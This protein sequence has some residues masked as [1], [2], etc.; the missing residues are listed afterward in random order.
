[1]RNLTALIVL[2]CLGLSAQAQK[3]LSV[4]ILHTND[5]HGH[6]LPYSY[7]ETFDPNEAIAR[8][9]VRRNIGGA[10]R[11]ASLVE[12]I[13][14]EK[15]RVVL[16][17]DSGDMMDGS[18]FSTEYKGEADM[19]VMNAIGLDA[20]VPGNHEF[21]N[22]FEQVQKLISMAKH[23]VVLANATRA[24]SGEPLAKPYIIKTVQG[25]RFGIFGLTTPSGQSYPGAVRDIR[26]EDPEAA[27]AKLVPIL[28]SQCDI[29]IAV[30]HIGNREDQ[31]LARKV[32]GI[33]IIVG[34][35]S[36]S[37]LPKH[38]LIP[39]STTTP[40]S[41]NG[42]LIVQAFQWSGVLGRLDIELTTNPS[43]KW[44][45]SRGEGRLLPITESIPEHKGVKKIVDSYWVPIAPKFGKV[46]CEA[47]DDIAHKGDDFAEYHMVADAIRAEMGTEVHF[48]NPGGVRS[49]LAKGPITYADLVNV[50]PFSNTV[51][52]FRVSGREL[53]RIL[54]RAKPAVSGIRYRIEN[55]VLTDAVVNGSPIDDSRIYTGSTNSFFA[56]SD[57][58]RGAEAMVDTGSPRLDVLIR[59]LEKQKTVTPRYDGRRVL[60]GPDNE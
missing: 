5:T 15:N 39:S 11:R 48:E 42:T 38:Q 7:P 51:V 35:H 43:G 32:P 6:L 21:N 30:T 28:R 27:A 23:P 3:R 52:T 4:T 1:M 20:Q 22:T 56:R 58:M 29:V 25:V 55:G 59:H 46:I 12:Q 9:A 36:H 13:R 49:T 31:D 60:K 33:D 19:A 45:V 17:T 14:R 37:L 16:V 40:G 54:L 26:I 2:L 57:A 24:G 18:P 53:K 44:V 34:G 10:A 47:A 50:D 41:I 8:L